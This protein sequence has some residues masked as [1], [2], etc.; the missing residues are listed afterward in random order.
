MWAQ[1]GFVTTLKGKK[2]G[3]IKY[4]CV[5]FAIRLELNTKIWPFFN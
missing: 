5:L 1:L 2:K 4:P 3:K